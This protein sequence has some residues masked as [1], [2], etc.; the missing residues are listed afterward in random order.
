MWVID[1][2]HDKFALVAANGHCKVLPKY[3][4]CIYDKSYRNYKQQK[5]SKPT[6]DSDELMK[7][8]DNLFDALSLFQGFENVNRNLFTACHQLTEA[9]RSYADYLTKAKERS[10]QNRNETDESI[11]E[12]LLEID[13][14]IENHLKPE[15]YQLN[16]TLNE[17]EFYEPLLVEGE[18]VPDDRKKRYHWFKDMK[19]C[20][21]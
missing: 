15:Y 11:R 9:L 12:T 8:S 13:C 19:L 5:K 4:S 6:L 3:F 14:V 7:H 10:Q 16:N 1:A 21:R 17:K 2:N 20:H 18:F